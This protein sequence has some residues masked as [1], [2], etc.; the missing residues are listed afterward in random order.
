VLDGEGG[1][2][3]GD[4]VETDQNGVS[5]EKE[6]NILLGIQKEV[7]FTFEVEDEDIHNR[8]V[9]LENND[10]LKNDDL[11]RERGNQ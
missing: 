2:N 5:M 9:E 10:K 11:V 4:T 3:H 6:A 7:G 8:L 1:V